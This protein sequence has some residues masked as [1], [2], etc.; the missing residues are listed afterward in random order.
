MAPHLRFTSVKMHV[1]WKLDRC[2]GSTRSLTTPLSSERARKTGSSPCPQAEGASLKKHELS[3]VLASSRLPTVVVC[4]AGNAGFKKRQANM[5]P[6]DLPTRSSLQAMAIRSSQY[7]FT[8]EQRTAVLSTFLQ[9]RRSLCLGTCRSRW[10]LHPFQT[11]H[12]S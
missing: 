10:S 8:F 5:F 7:G 6:V 3:C 2:R 9:I 4:L 1:S 12:I 11:S